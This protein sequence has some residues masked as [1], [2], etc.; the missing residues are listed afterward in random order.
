MLHGVDRVHHP[1]ETGESTKSIDTKHQMRTPPLSGSP[2]KGVIVDAGSRAGECL[3]SR[4][5]AHNCAPAG[6]HPDYLLT[7]GAHQALSATD[8]RFQL[9][10]RD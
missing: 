4:D 7:P 5:D 1:L 2:D 9:G 6:A 10:G 8:W 3:A